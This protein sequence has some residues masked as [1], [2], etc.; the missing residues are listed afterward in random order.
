MIEKNPKG[1]GQETIS[2][3]HGQDPDL[4]KIRHYHGTFQNFFS[5]WKK[6]GVVTDPYKGV[7]LTHPVKKIQRESTLPY[8]DYGIPE[9]SKKNKLLESFDEFLSS[10]KVD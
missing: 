6:R 2:Y 5:Y 4:E 1:S 3:T 8:Q 7:E 9:I 10:Q